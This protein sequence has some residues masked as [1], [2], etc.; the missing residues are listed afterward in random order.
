MVGENIYKENDKNE[1]EEKF[2]EKFGEDKVT[3]IE[4]G[5]PETYFEV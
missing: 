3:F 1:I 2:I 4:D 5:N